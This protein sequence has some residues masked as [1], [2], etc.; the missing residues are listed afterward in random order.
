MAQKFQVS[1]F[2]S[3]VIGREWD[4]MDLNTVLKELPATSPQGP[5][6]G[7]G[8]LRRSIAAMP[9]E[10][11]FDFFFFDEGQLKHFC[12]GL[13]AAGLTK[14]KETQHHEQWEGYLP[15]A[16]RSVVIQ[17]IKFQYY[18]TA[19]EVIESFDF[20]VCQFSYDGSNVYAADYALWDL[21]RKRLAVN[22]ISFPVSSMRRL[23]K[24]T[25][26][27]YTACDGCLASLATAVADNPALANLLHIQY[28]D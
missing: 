8:A 25:R 5:W 27:G 19:E 15:K 17:C 24:Y 1:E 10:S 9:L 20:T 6:L 3:R 26:Q 28:V 7:G 21:G 12:E 18:K 4:E 23:L 16:K 11:D 2:F 14:E 22:K 13:A